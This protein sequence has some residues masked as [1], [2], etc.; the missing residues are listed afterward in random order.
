MHIYK[1][2]KNLGISVQTHWNSGSGKPLMTRHCILYISDTVNLYSIVLIIEVE[3]QNIGN[4]TLHEMNFI[5]WDYKTLCY[6]SRWDY[7]T[8]CSP[9]RWDYKTLGNL[10]RQK[11]IFNHCTE[12]YCTVLYCIIQHCTV[13]YWTVL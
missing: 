8:S 5:Y 13:L 10:S 2:T 12:L 9:R 11:Y 1:Q 6:P 7:K 3:I 4:P